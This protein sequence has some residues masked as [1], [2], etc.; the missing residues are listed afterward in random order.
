MKIGIV[1]LGLMGGSFGRT[2]IRQ[3]YTVYGYDTSPDVMLKAEL[4][5]AISDKLTL[6]NASKVELLI[7]AI[8]PDKIE[9]V[10]SEFVPK[11]KKGTIV[12]DFCG[13]K[14]GVVSLMKKYVAKYP[15]ITFVGGHPMAGREFSGTDWSFSYSPL[16]A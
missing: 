6:E 10:L 11:L 13:I 5:K 16:W 1:G 2:L 7:L 4:M 14:T 9:S 3:G 8:T 15:E 12:N